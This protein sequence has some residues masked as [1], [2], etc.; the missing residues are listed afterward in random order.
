MQQHTN[1]KLMT[2]KLFFWWPVCGNDLPIDLC[3]QS[4]KS[5]N[6]YFRLVSVPIDLPI[7]L[8]Q[9]ANGLPG[10][11]RTLLYVTK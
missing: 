11:N 5:Y 6:P 1:V 4:A 2:I 9:S 8:W 10:K 7:D 3:W